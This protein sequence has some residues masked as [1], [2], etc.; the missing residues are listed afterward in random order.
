[1]SSIPPDWSPPFKEKR[2]RR[3]KMA[4]P[5]LPLCLFCLEE[6]KEREDIQ[7]IVGCRCEI[8]AHSLCLQGWFQQK[9]QLECPICHAVSVPN[10]IQLVRPEVIVVHVQ[11]P[12]QQGQIRRLRSQEKCVGFC[13]LTILFWWIGAMILEF[14]I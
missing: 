13:C 2:K 9:Q 3:R 4:E 7:N 1:M 14:G 12:E 6:L 11:D 5:M 10:P 8:H